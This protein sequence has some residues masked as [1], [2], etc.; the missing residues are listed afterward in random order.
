MKSRVGGRL[1]A[2]LLVLG[3]AAACTSTGP[4]SRVTVPLGEQM[5]QRGVEPAQVVVPFEIDAELAQWARQRV[6]N[7]LDMNRRLDDLLLALLGSGEITLTYEADATGTAAEVFASGRANC[8]AF[9]FLFAGLAR[10]VGIPVDFLLV[11][12]V[13]RFSREGD[14]I[15]VSEHATVVFGEGEDRRILEFRLGPSLDYRRAARISDITAI[16]LYYSNLGAQALRAGELALARER[17]EIA[18][19][20][21]PRLGQ[22]WTN[23]GVARRRTGDVP[24]AEA[25][26]FRALEI[27]PKNPSAYQNLAALAQ[28]RGGQQSALDL[29]SRVEAIDSQNPYSYLALGD[30]AAALGNEAEAGRF[31]REALRR[32]P[33]TAE[34]F[35]A[36]GLWNLKAGELRTA[37]RM[38]KKAQKIDPTAP[39]VDSLEGR[40]AGIA[41]S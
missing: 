16:A 10:S 31:Y 2:G 20:L 36:L 24:G 40:L 32:A 5:R 34:M 15:I 18:A 8:L 13:E 33:H 4:K 23:L 7:T 37:R 1:A 19:R 3:L 35:A 30:L 25:A 6:S 28:S 38:L 26:Y 21:D 14:F 41:G 12:E 39:R 9:A 22:A 27:D 17:L 29:L 11:P